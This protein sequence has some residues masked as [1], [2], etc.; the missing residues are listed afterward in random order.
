M[1]N[2]LVTYTCM[3]YVHV[4]VLC[5]CIYISHMCVYKFKKK[6]PY[7][8]L[9]RLSMFEYVCVYKYTRTTHTHTHTCNHNCSGERNVNYTSF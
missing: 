9:K 3:L 8:I 6:N 4:C 2:N 7:P 5:V 1:Y